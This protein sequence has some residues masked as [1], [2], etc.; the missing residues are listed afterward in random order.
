MTQKTEQL[1][2]WILDMDYSQPVNEHDVYQR[3]LKLIL[4][5]IFSRTEDQQLLILDGTDSSYA[6]AETALVNAIWRMEWELAPSNSSFTSWVIEPEQIASYLEAHGISLLS[7]LDD[8][9]ALL[10]VIRYPDTRLYLSEK[11]PVWESG[12]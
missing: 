12:Q 3:I 8:V 6:I 5:D 10:D 7:I 1:L 9:A 4:Q 2:D 11:I